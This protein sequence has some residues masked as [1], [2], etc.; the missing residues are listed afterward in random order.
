MVRLVEFDITFS[1]SERHNFLISCLKYRLCWWRFIPPL[2]GFT[3]SVFLSRSLGYIFDVGWE[4]TGVWY[5]HTLSEIPLVDSDFFDFTINSTIG[6]I[7]SLLNV[8]LRSVRST[9][10]CVCFVLFCIHFSYIV[11]FLVVRRFLFSFWSQ[12]CVYFLVFSYSFW[13]LFSVSWFSSGFY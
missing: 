8:K 11:L 10:D 6:N 1:T 9:V 3:L 7:S 5:V 4:T 12:G 2:G 13:V